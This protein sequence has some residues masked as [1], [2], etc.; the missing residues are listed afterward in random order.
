MGKDAKVAAGGALRRF[1][2]SPFH[3]LI[4]GTTYCSGIS[5][6]CPH[7]G[8]C[9]SAQRGARKALPS[10]SDTARKTGGC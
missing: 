7:L 2:R 8:V 3:V 5:V 4:W 6:G 10:E 9:H 1:H